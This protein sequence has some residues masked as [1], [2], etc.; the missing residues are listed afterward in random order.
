MKYLK[1]FEE[2]VNYDYD[3]ILRIL[4]KNHGWG[5][6]SA[7][8]FMQFEKDNEYFLNPQDSNDYA[9]QFHVFFTDLQSGRLRGTFHKEPSGLRLGTWKTSISVKSST[10]IYN[11]LT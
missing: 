2:L 7:N 8:Y 3:F 6:A 1:F 11:K 9:N 10:S 5:N 4:R